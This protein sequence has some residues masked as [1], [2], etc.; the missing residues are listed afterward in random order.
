MTN[1]LV[2]VGQETLELAAGGLCRR[3]ASGQ[4][5]DTANRIARYCG[6]QSVGLVFAA[7]AYILPR[8]AMA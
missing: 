3:I 1:A 7:L 6:A 5:R 8:L 2:V 4:C